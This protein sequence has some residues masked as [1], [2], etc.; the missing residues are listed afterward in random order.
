M[1]WKVDNMFGDVEEQ[2]NSV[3]KVSNHLKSEVA[4]S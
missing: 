1:M 4:N 2:N 3:L